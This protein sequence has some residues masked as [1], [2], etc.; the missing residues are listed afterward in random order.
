ML[1]VGH[2]KVGLNRP[3]DHVP[4]LD[5]MRGLAI[6]LVLIAHFNG[7]AVLKEYFPLAG[8]IITKLALTGLMGVDLFFVLSGFLITGILL[9]TKGSKRFFSNFYARRVLRIFPLYFGVLAL[10]FLVLPTLVNLDPAAH[11]I[12]DKQW[13]LWAYLSNFPGHPAWDE[14]KLFALGHFWSLAVEE[15]FYLIW[16]F[17]VF[18]VSASQLKKVCLSWVAIS[19]AAGLASYLTDGEVS[20]NL[21]WT[22]ICLSGSLTLGAY[23]ALVAREKSGLATLTSSAKKVI[24]PCGCSLLLLGMLPRR[25]HPDLVNLLMHYVSWVFFSSLLVYILTSSKDSHLYRLFCSGTMVVFGKLSYGL[26]VFHGV[27]RPTFETYFD[28]SALIE[29]MGSP[30][31]GTLIYFALSIGSSFAIAWFSWHLYEKHFLKLKRFFQ[32]SRMTKQQQA[33]SSTAS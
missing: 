11:E 3:Q 1:K 24:I 28:R 19:V 30:L 7:E 5:G 23:C 9:D 21:R 10:I 18:S 31:L 15:H 6:L 16:P 4:V 26:Y 13:W 8:P 2:Q 32:A 12:V 20:R 25:I 14:S 33:I 29:A 27:L 17:V 22:T